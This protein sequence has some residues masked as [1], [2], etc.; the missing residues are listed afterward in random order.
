MYTTTSLRT[1]YGKLTLD[2]STEN[3]TTGDALMNDETREI[4]GMRDWPFSEKR[5]NLATTANQQYVDLPYDFDKLV[6]VSVVI[7]SNRYVPQEAPSQAAW[8]EINQQ[9]TTTTN[10]PQWFF[11]YDNRVYF[12]P[13]PS[14]TGST[15]SLTYRARPVDLVLAD[16]TTG[17]VTTDGTATVVG[18]G[19][20]WTKLN[21]GWKFK[22]TPS[23]T[24]ATDGDG[25]WYEI[26][27]ITNDTTIVLTRAYA[28]ANV[29]GAAYTAG[30]SSILPEAYQD[31]PAY[32]AAVIYF[33]GLNPDIPRAEA[34]EVLRER[35][36][37]QLIK[38]HCTRTLDPVM[39]RTDESIINPNL[40]VTL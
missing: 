24:A 28:G 2:Q 8:D 1:L 26:A 38:D 20:T 34:M 11:V 15:V 6:T 36:L 18:S 14:S 31:L 27:S 40:L 9:T 29:T 23:T 4:V 22:I 21:V 5:I 19:T 7:G 17:T 32:G 33:T 30:Q 37:K 12:Y 25:F 35:K 13:I 3:I 16:Y 39:N 10:Y